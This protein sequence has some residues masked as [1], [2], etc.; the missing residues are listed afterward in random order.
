MPREA[1]VR[2]YVGLGSNL[3]VPLQQMASAL[4]ALAALT[5]TRVVRASSFYRTA[6]VGYAGQPD[7]VNAVVA[8]D[9]GLAPRALLDALLGIEREHGR[10]RTVPNG[11]RT[12]DLDLLAYGDVRLNEPGLTV[13]HPRMHERAFVMVPLA[14]IAPDFEV[15]GHGMAARLARVLAVAQRVERIASD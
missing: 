4:D 14:E 9:T 3:S 6:P 5:D 15:A 12:L 13:P 10:V 8:I 11:P 2:A 1:P 7:F